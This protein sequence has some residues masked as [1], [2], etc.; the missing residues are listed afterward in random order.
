MYNNVQAARLRY[1][2]TSR[3]RTFGNVPLSM[4]IPN[5]PPLTTFLLQ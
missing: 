1:R 2:S 3:N 5:F 4:Q